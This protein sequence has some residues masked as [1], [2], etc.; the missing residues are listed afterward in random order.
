MRV[1]HKRRREQ[2]TDYKLRLKLLKSGKTRLV[3]RRSLDNIRVQFVNF[4]ING[5]KTESSSISSELKKMGWN[6]GTGN[7]PAAYLTGFIAG[8]KTKTKEAILDIGMHMN[9]K[10]S[11]IYAALKGVIDAG[12][13]VPHSEEI[14]PD[15]ER[16]MGKHINPE[17]ENSVNMIIEKIK[18]Q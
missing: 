13:A 10:G 14:L 9:T 8:S 17:I 1:S 18:K 5:D 15:M 2:K 3:I 7:L 16:I 4:N 11:R 12:I 6:H